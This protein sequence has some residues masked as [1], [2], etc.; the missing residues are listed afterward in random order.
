MLTSSYSATSYA[1][2]ACKS[3]RLTS[4]LTTLPATND[5][6]LASFLE[7]RL[8]RGTMFAGSGQ[9]VTIDLG[10]EPAQCYY[11][12]LNPRDSADDDQFLVCFV[13]ECNRGL[14][15]FRNQLD[16]YAQIMETA[17]KSTDMHNISEVMTP[18]L[19][20]WYTECLLFIVN[21]VKILGKDI[22]YV[23]YNAIAN[24]D[25]TVDTDDK[26]FEG[27]LEKFH[28]ACTLSALLSSSAES[29]AS[30]ETSGSL[31]DLEPEP[32]SVTKKH[33]NILSVTFRDGQ[34]SFSDHGCSNFCERWAQSLLEKFAYS[35]AQD[36]DVNPLSLR[37]ITE[38]YKLKTIQDMNTLKRAVKDAELDYYALFRS[39]VFVRNSGNSNI[40]LM[41]A[42]NEEQT[43]ESAAILKLLQEKTAPGQVQTVD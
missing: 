13:T 22:K 43:D 33:V 24:G 20:N 42:I 41:H 19:D 15:S 37:T 30:S 1:F 12:L 3:N 29:A 5:H 28:A 9:I 16:Q 27:D 34:I 2:Y 36:G 21:C 26:Q 38:M 32:R 23:I 10:I 7:K 8:T 40:L 4:L 11:C 14:E 18:L 35:C 31:I 6:D 39:L 17:L 25:V